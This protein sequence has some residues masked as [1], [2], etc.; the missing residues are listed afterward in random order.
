[1]T[2]ER[3]CEH[4]EVNKNHLI[5]LKNRH[6]KTENKK[7]LN[8]LLGNIKICPICHLDPRSRMKKNTESKVQNFLKF[9]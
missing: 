2:E 8:N 7:S 5:V 6:K 1:M 4:E 9:N 3:L